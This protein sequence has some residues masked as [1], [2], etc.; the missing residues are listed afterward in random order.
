[1]G[2]DSSVEAAAHQDPL[3]TH[4]HV[5]SEYSFLDGSIRIKELIKKAKSLGHTHVA[6][7]DHHNMHGAIDFYTEAKS[8]GLI[9]IVGCEIYH[10][11]FGDM[12]KLAILAGDKE[13]EPY[14]RAHLL[15]LA[16]DTKGYKN[17]IKIVSQGYC[18]EGFSDLP[19]VLA[20]EWEHL[21]GSGIVALSAC[22]MGQMG[23]LVKLLRKVSGTEQPL[24]LDPSHP[25]AGVILQH[26]E[27]FIQTMHKIFGTKQF[28]VELID[29]N[30]PGQK[31]FLDDLVTIAEHFSLKIV[32]TA[33]AHYLEPDFS[34]IHALAVAIK[35]SLTLDDIRDR[36]KEARFHLTDN[37]EME[38]I[39]Q[40]WP[41]A[42]AH[43]ME[44]ANK[45]S[46]LHI[47]TGVHYLPKI[48]LDG[49]EPK[50]A[51]R[52]IAIDGL[53]K[54]FDVLKDFYKDGF[55]PEKQEEYWQRLYYEL[56]MIEQMGFPDYFLIVQD[57]INWAKSQKIPVGPGRGSG[58]G[59]LV[60]YALRITDLDPLPYNLIFERFL[61]PE[62]VSL[63]DFDVDFCQWRR[64][65]VIQYC[66]NKYGANQVAQ[67]T[68]FGKMMA[69]GA[70]KSVGRAMNINFNRMDRFTKLFPPD[71]GMSLKEALATEPRLK[72][73]MAKDDQLKECMDYALKLEGLVSHTSVHAA[74]IVISDGPMTNYLPI[75]TTDGKS[76]ITQFEMK[77]TEKIGL[78]KFDFLGLKTLTVIDKAV[79][80]ITKTKSISLNMEK[81]PM[82]DQKVYQMISAGHTC[83]IFQCEGGGMTQLILKLRPSNFEDVIALVALFRPGPLG[84]GM[85]DDFVERKHGRQEIVYSHPHLE[86]IL[87]DTYGMILYQ[88]Q[89]QKIAA[90]L[91]NYNL[92][93]AD[94]LRRAMGKKIPGEMAK[95]K[96][97]FVSGARENKIDDALSEQIFDLMAEFANYGFNKSHSAAYGLVSYH[98]AYLK[99]HFPE[100]FLAASMTCDMDNTDKIVR[101]VEDCHRL[102]FQVL[103]PSIH[104]SD[105]EFLV[106]KNQQISFALPAIKGVGVQA[107]RLLL[108]NRTSSGPFKGL[109]DLAKRVNLNKVGKKTLL[110]LAQSGAFDD[111]NYQRKYIESMIEPLVAYSQNLHEKAAAGQRSLFDFSFDD[112]L[113]PPQ[114]FHPWD[115][116]HLQS[117]AH[118]KALDLSDLLQEKKILGVYLS[119]HPLDLYAVDRRCFSPG[120]SLKA[121]IAASNENA[122]TEKEKDGKWKKGRKPFAIIALFGG[123]Q[124]RRTKKGTMM[125]YIRLEEPYFACEAL[126]FEASLK[127]TKLPS[128]DEPVLAIGYVDHMPGYQPRLTVEHVLTIPEVRESRI[129]ELWC[130]LELDPDA[131]QQV[132]IAALEQFSNA[133][134]RGQTLVQFFIHAQLPSSSKKVKAHLIGSDQKKILVDE[135]FLNQLKKLP[136]KRIG[137]EYKIK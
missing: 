39:F 104:I 121:L 25:V 45:C 16:Q 50:D 125:A 77:P 137:Y 90:V 31:I 66:I 120:V 67:I 114:E 43:T 18:Y 70:V 44:I 2:V 61:N 24:C 17:L 5:H 94:L 109:T 97:R 101:Y 98:T 111:L 15:L 28:Y 83:G 29:N 46:G 14:E 126:M 110:L 3:F 131:D 85:V 135:Q 52:Q 40:K 82:D 63:P 48:T 53:K 35:N 22:Q 21:D 118:R 60:A 74:G 76:Y 108:E 12:K 99:T 115:E 23:Y 122:G 26:L 36:L 1:M 8:A 38:L 19:K 112:T 129:N 34:H 54:R 134:K 117:L 13:P 123:A 113:P 68:T 47:Q 56:K 20:S 11:P 65:E 4:L 119:A 6:L 49:I 103:N 73:E 64:E 87:K 127:E 30:L 81:I 100:E 132:L 78:V 41:E 84:S 80:L 69:K 128:Q 10:E 33:D 116:P 62:R 79:H 124:L 57:F 92:G 102:G 55:T 133:M 96:D 37:E 106:P 107:V 89:V 88:E 130:Y 32:G 51:L 72:E 95:Q 136:V 42:L 105:L 27:D 7:T 9:P 59:S 93:E 86:P 58:A 91:A 75:Y 71:I